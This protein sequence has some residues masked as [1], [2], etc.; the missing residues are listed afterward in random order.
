MNGHGAQEPM[1]NQTQDDLMQLTLQL[2]NKKENDKKYAKFHG[3]NLIGV[4][5]KRCFFECHH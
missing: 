5:E 2:R 4:S 1:S 3:D